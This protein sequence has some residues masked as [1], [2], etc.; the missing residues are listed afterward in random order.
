MERKRFKIRKMNKNVGTV[1]R[2][3]R[4]ILAVV[5]LALLLLHQV[6]GGI[7]V[8]LGFAAIALAAT[9]SLRVCPCYARLN[10]KTNKDESK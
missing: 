5:I 4:I 7:A 3:I 2:I 9:G 1:D 6:T 8:F 10:I